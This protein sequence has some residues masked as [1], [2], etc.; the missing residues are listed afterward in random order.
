M[1]KKDKSLIW[2]VISG[3]L[4]IALC[5]VS[6]LYFMKLNDSNSFNGKVE[7]QTENPLSLW[8]ENSM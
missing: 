1:E 4:V 3:V 7:I 2:K 8:T 5:T 6:C